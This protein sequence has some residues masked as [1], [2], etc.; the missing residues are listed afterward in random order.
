M[1]SGVASHDSCRVTAP[2]S[3]LPP[4]P[5]PLGWAHCE[6]NPSAGGEPEERK[7]KKKK[8]KEQPIE[9]KN[10]LHLSLSL[11]TLPPGFHAQDI[12]LPIQCPLLQEVVKAIGFFRSEKARVFSFSSFSSFLFFFLFFFPFLSSKDAPKWEFQWEL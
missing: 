5:F 7:M 9:S 1:V 12:V 6:E 10:S 3:W 2:I 8:E 4:Y 11:H